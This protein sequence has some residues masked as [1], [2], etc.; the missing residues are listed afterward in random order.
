MNRL[1]QRK[2]TR[3]EPD[4]NP[5]ARLLCNAR[6]GSLL[7]YRSILARLREWDIRERDI[8]E[9]DMG[10]RD[11]GERNIG[12]RDIRER[13]IGQRDISERDIQE[14]AIRETVA[15]CRFAE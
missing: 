7:A 14:K 2:L 9:S 6:T 13:D 5:N 15:T 12:E 1:Q 8:G 3:Q 4:S 10:K 11:I